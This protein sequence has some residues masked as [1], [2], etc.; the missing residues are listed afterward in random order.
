[1]H[2]LAL[3]ILDGFGI[4]KPNNTN[5]IYIARTP[6]FDK[7]WK[8]YPHTTLQASG[9]AVG[10]PK[11]QIGGSEVGHLTIGAG[12]VLYQD[13]VRIN[14]SFKEP[15]NQKYGIKNKKNF[16]KF[17]SSSKIKP[18]HLLGM[19]SPGGIHS[20]Q[21]H[22]FEI[23]KIMHEAGCKEPYLH[24]ISDG[25]DTFPTSGKKYAKELVDLI[26]KL[27]FGK[28]VGVTGRFYGMDRDHNWDRTDQ[29][30][31]LMTEGKA[32]K[33][34]DNLIAAFEKNYEDELT[35]ELQVSTK[36]LLGYNGIKENE[37]I[38][39]W[40]FRSDRMKQI[41][42][43]LG[44]TLPKSQ[45][46]TMTQYDKTYNYPVFFEKQKLSNTLAEVISKNGIKQL[47]TAETDKIPH[48][49]Y[50]FNGGVEVI[51]PQEL[52]AFVEST[53]VTYD[54]SPKMRAHTIVDTVEKQYAEN[55]DLGF[56]VI[57]FCNAD[58]V[59]HFGVFKSS[60]IAV[61]TVD[62]ELKRMCDFLTEKGFICV[63]TADH[64]NA[65]EMIDEATGQIRTA[66]SMNPIPFII[67]DPNHISSFHR[68]PVLDAESI[69]LDQKKE[70][71]LSRVATTVLKLMEIEIPSEYDEGLI[72]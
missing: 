30:F 51:F 43:K 49:T 24:I 18:A 65:D 71:G 39:F 10:L 7:I 41:I 3:I 67:Y 28:I 55:E 31:E 6:F 68:H 58:L 63:I 38:L 53:K 26:E 5:A 27:H 16:Q 23:L 44:G 1:M 62:Q 36:I 15:G 4:G 2:K 32:H 20:D 35:D 40:N 21:K 12:R 13:L 29:L 50:F 14:L 52:H 9:L 17:I 8:E 42:T 48:V 70:N 72:K 25:R 11:G 47:K 66:H 37:P 60:V 34:A 54:K 33:N 57:N 64:G 56:A 69:L 45:F 61:E 59:S 22:L 19:L 46:F